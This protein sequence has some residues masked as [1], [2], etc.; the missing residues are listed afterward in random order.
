MTPGRINNPFM[1][2]FAMTLDALDSWM[3]ETGS[4]FRHEP[5]AR[6]AFMLYLIILHLW[7][8]ALVMFHMAEEPHADFGSLD[9]NPRH[10]RTAAVDAKLRQD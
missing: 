10:W 1:D 2:Q 9:T 7:S 3:L 6:L 4:F 5:L 8:F